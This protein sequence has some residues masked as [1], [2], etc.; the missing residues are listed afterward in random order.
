MCQ[1]NIVPV[2][3]PSPHHHHR[4]VGK[5]ERCGINVSAVAV[6]PSVAELRVD[7]DRY[8]CPV[9]LRAEGSACREIDLVGNRRD[10]RVAGAF[11][12]VLA[13]CET[14]DDIPAMTTVIIS[15]S[16]ATYKQR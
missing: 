4:T 1:V 11:Y 3:A 6:L 12:P 8:A 14:N 9:G 10:E 15:K 5:D 2:V 7:I 13:V 16:D